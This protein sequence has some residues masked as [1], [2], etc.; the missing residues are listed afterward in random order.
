[1]SVLAEALS[2][3]V[4]ADILQTRYP[5]GLAGYARDCPNA[6]LCC[7]GHLARVGF[8]S[9]HDVDFL[10][11]VLEAHG[12]VHLAGG[13][14]IDAVVVDQHEGPLSP[15]LWIEFGTD[16]DGIACC[17]AADAP[18]VPLAVPIGWDRSC[19][20][21]VVPATRDRAGRALHTRDDSRMASYLGRRGRLA[22]SSAF[23][24]H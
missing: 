6:S 24:M 2:V 5:G 14:A 15:C 19:H 20:E 4:R 16:A 10:L 1:M 13:V 3:V 23:V 12:V 7:D 22:T 17:R 18:D 9:P 11:N 8:L 21:A